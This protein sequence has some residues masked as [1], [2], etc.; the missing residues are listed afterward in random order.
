SLKRKLDALKA[1][2][3]SLD[4]SPIPS[5]SED[6]PSPTGSDS[7]SGSGNGDGN[8]GRCLEQQKDNRDIED[9]DMSDEEE[10]TA[11][12]GI[13]VDER[14]EKSSLPSVSKITNAATKSSQITASKP[15]QVLAT[16]TKMVSGSS[17]NQTPPANTT[18][19]TTTPAPAP[20]VSPSP[21]QVNLANVDLGKISSILSSLSNAMKTT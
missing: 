14:K 3:P 2:L 18:P 12:A 10:T 7:R 19:I 21:L 11:N 8:G 13:V 5:P 9:M 4:E 20:V 15:S 17:A 6:A 16:P 1:T